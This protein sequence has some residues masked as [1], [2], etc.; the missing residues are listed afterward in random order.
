MVS[1]VVQNLTTSV[2]K[3]V[4]DLTDEVGEQVKDLIVHQDFDFDD[5]KSPTWNFTFDIDDLP[6]IPDANLRSTF[7]ELELYMLIDATLSLGATYTLPLYKSKTPLGVHITDNLELGII[8]DVELILSAEAAI[9]I[10]SGF[11]LKIDDGF[12]ID[13]VLFGKIPSNLKFNGGQFELLPVTIEAGGVLPSAVLRVDVHTGMQL[14]TPD[15]PSW[16]F[17]SRTF[18][19]S[20]GGGIEVGVFANIAEMTTN[21]TYIPD[22]EECALAVVQS[23]KLALGANAGATIH[24]GT[25]RWGPAIK[26]P[27][28]IY[29]TE[30]A[31][32]CAISG[33][34]ASTSAVPTA[35]DAAIVRRQGLSELELVHET[36][37]TAVSCVSTGLINCPASLQ[38]T[39]TSSTTITLTTAVSSGVDE[40]ALS[41][42][43][44]PGIDARQVAAAIT[45][46]A[47]GTNAVKSP[48]TSGS[49][50]PYVAA[51][52]D[53]ADDI[54]DDIKD[55]I[56]GLP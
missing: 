52:T 1:G 51:A 48:T 11:H 3:Y 43:I 39:S 8:F 6:S 41:R 40:K 45:T 17:A 56:K 32:G 46:V 24:V 37:Y 12:A 42:S 44:W 53:T 27:T 35:T 21:V 54:G 19:G 10:G 49:P 20:I 28:A 33:T 38:T 2:G 9:I 18:G 16:S 4:D 26:N 50:I 15:L 23:Y 25:E 55:A 36:T 47:F 7:D 34:P 13:I 14:A 22:D 30:L 5:F 29:T 31:S